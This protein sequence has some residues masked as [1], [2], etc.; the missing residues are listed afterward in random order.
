MPEYSRGVKLT[1]KNLLSSICVTGVT[2]PT[3]LKLKSTGVKKKFHTLL[4][5]LIFIK[6]L[7]SNHKTIIK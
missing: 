1:S 4:N 7:I 3:K 5:L 2:H 6:V